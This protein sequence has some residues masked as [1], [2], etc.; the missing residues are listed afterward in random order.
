MDSESGTMSTSGSLTGGDR[1]I[2]VKSSITGIGWRA[3]Y[4]PILEQFVTTVSITTNH[5]Y[6]FSKFTFLHELD[7]GTDFDM[8]SYINKDFFSEVWIALIDY[9]K[10]R[11]RAAKTVIYH[12]LIKHHLDAY[13][14]AA[15]YQQPQLLFQQYSGVIQKSFETRY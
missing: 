3:Q 7:N 8:A 12:T 2:S 6:S 5:A 9:N 14:I 4:L 1:I 10:E 13:L 11:V 15:S